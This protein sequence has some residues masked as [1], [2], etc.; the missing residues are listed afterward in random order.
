MAQEILIRTLEERLEILENEHK[1]LIEV[2]ITCEITFVHVLAAILGQL[3]IAGVMAPADTADRLART[4]IRLFETATTA[5]LR[6]I[7]SIENAL[8]DIRSERSSGGRPRRH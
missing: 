3:E 8:C 4:Q 1:N 5:N 7:D 2:C 6:L